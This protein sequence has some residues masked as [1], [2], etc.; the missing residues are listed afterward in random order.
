MNVKQ[1]NLRLSQWNS[2]AVVAEIDPLWQLW[3]DGSVID[4]ARAMCEVGLFGLELLRDF[5]RLIDAEMGHV[6]VRS[7]GIQYQGIQ[8]LEKLH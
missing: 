3:I 6:T 4:S 8:V 7:Q 2:Q 5:R 1:R